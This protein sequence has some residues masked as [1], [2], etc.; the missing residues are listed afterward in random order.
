VLQLSYKSSLDSIMEVYGL[1]SSS[2]SPMQIYIRAK[3]KGRAKDEQILTS[4]TG[5]RRTVPVKSGNPYK[6]IRG[7]YC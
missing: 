6:G 7:K 1:N 4:H 5:K 3:E 2:N